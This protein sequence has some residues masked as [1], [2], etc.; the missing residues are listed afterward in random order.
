MNEVFTSLFYTIIFTVILKAL[1]FI[2]IF[3]I[4]LLHLIVMTI[5]KIE[6]CK[7]TLKWDLWAHVKLE[8]HF[9]INAQQEKL[10]KSLLKLFV[11]NNIVWSSHYFKKMNNL[12]WYVWMNISAPHKLS[13]K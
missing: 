10:Y 13:F 12:K 6:L 4:N 5:M 11:K 1:F 3:L 8:S 7:K 9:Q 2:F